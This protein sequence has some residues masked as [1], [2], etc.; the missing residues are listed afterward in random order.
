MQSFHSQDD[1]TR[2][3]DLMRS[4]DNANSIIF[5]VVLVWWI[6]CLWIDEPGAKNRDQGTGIRDQESGTGE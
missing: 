4:L 6:I 3:V 2:A 1:Y 5:I